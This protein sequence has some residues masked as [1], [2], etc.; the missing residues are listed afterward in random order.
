MINKINKIMK[1]L[2]II[3]LVLA[4]APVMSE[5]MLA[6]GEDCGDPYDARGS[7][8]GGPF[9][10]N[11]ATKTREIR[12]VVDTHFTPY[13]E[14]ILVYGSTNRIAVKREERHSG[15]NLYVGNVDYTLRAIPNHPRALYASAVW[16]L[17][18][19]NESLSEFQ[20]LQRAWNFRSSECYFVRAKMFRPQDHMVYMVYAM[21]QSKAGNFDVA[22]QNYKDAARLAPESAEV[23]Y[24]LGLLYLDL[25]QYANARESASK[26]YELG[27]PLPGLRDELT[28]LGKW[29][30]VEEV[31]EA[32]GY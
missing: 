20:R 28:R 30:D 32:A 18:L 5:G 4:S 12:R 31:A 22:L 24:N 13:T 3:S 9:D 7:G 29:T 2:A 25:K 15:R 23:H 19:R 1:I 6:P 14:E 26:A 21:Y 10:F 11:D 17:R 16:Q 8:G 27:Y